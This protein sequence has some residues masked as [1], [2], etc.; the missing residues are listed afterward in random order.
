MFRWTVPVAAA[1]CFCAT[2]IVAQEYVTEA[3]ASF[4]FN[5]ERVKISRD[6]P[7]AVR[8]VSRFAAAGDGCGAPCIAPMT[9]AQGVDTLDET[10][11]LEFL[12]KQVAGNKGLMIDARSPEARAE[13]FIPGTVNLPHSTVQ[14]DNDFKNDILRALGARE[15]EG[16][17]NFAD[18]RELLIYDNGPSTDDAGMLIN[19]LMALG[20][21]AEKLK[22]YRG[23]MQVWAVLGFSIEEERT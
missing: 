12:V 9:V 7:D 14:S 1:A 4:I 2:A 5:G 18:A 10:Q 20:Y 6:N 17:F 21:P 16:T 19:N 23:G 13:G 8:F 11:V 22:Y 3:K 15:F